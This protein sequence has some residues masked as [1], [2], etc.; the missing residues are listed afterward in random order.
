MD[1]MV[2]EESP[3]VIWLEVARQVPGQD[4][5]CGRKI[6]IW[7]LEQGLQRLLWAGPQAPEDAVFDSIS[8]HTPEVEGPFDGP[9]L[10]LKRLGPGP[11]MRFPA[12]QNGQRPL[13]GASCG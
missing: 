6:A 13:S 2:V 7:S 9:K 4:E 3:E 12:P 5:G 10:G 11:G 8:L 1:A